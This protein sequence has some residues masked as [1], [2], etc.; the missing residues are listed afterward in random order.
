MTTDVTCGK[1]RTGQIGALSTSLSCKAAMLVLPW[2]TNMRLDWILNDTVLLGGPLMNR[3][4]AFH[5]E[6]SPPSQ[7]KKKMQSNPFNHTSPFFAT[8]INMIYLDIFAA[9]W[10]ISLMNNSSIGL[11]HTAKF[12]VGQVA[13][14]RPPPSQPKSCSCSNWLVE[15]ITHHYDAV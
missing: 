4:L 5:S 7:K 8:A 13:A 15:D 6:W 9:A 11:K 3:L 1:I 2:H 12:C 10:I 14:T